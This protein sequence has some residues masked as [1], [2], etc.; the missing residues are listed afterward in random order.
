MKSFTYLTKYFV[1]QFFSIFVGTG[2]TLVFQKLSR[3]HVQIHAWSLKNKQIP[4]GSGF[5]T[6]LNSVYCS[7]QRQKT[8]GKFLVSNCNVLFLVVKREIERKF[9]W[10]A[11][12]PSPPPFPPPGDSVKLLLP[13]GSKPTGRNHLKIIHTTMQPLLLT[14]SDIFLWKIYPVYSVWYL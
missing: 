3:I 2:I 12:P 9:P 5:A 10:S 6:L 14:N 13:V 4:P 11:A 7:L 1:T 8:A